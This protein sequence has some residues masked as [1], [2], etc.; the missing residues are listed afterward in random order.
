[1][2]SRQ[3]DTD[4]I[5][6]WRE[7]CSQNGGMEATTVNRFR[8]GSRGVVGIGL[9][10]GGLYWY[11]HRPVHQAD[12]NSVAII[13]KE[14]PGFSASDDAK[15]LELTYSLENT[16][17]RDYEISSASKMKLLVKGNDGVLSPPIGAKL[18]EVFHL[19]VFIPPH[20]KARLELSIPFTGI[21][22]RK[23]SEAG[24][25]YH[26]RLRDFL[27][28]TLSD[29]TFVL[30]DEANRYRINLTKWLTEAPKKTTP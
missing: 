13:C 30:F 21:P 8:L 5:W 2:L 12:W 15:R 26:E 22:Q 23:S 10:L 25:E 24:Q 7:D 19:P 27:N 3:H 1:M 16:T 18:D 14:A 9:V 4:M 20:Q 17:D 29:N 11:K 28:E 6:C